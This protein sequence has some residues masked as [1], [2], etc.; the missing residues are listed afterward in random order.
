MSI[1]KSCE[2]AYPSEAC[3]LLTGNTISKTLLHVERVICAKNILANNTNDR[4]EVDPATRIRLEKEIRNTDEK[5][6]AHF[7]SHPDNKAVP[8]IHDLKSVNEPELIWVIIS[9]IKGM[10]S[11]I[12]AHKFDQTSKSFNQVRL[13]VN[14]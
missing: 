9:V 7:H 4:F 2:Q 11:E 12:T 13:I 8:S 6:I 1:E 14:D 5:L 3:G 10:A